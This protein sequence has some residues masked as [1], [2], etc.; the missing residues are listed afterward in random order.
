MKKLLPLFLTLFS[1]AAFSWTDPTM[2]KPL[3]P[4]VW[5]DQLKPTL[6]EG[7]D[8]TG[9]TMLATGLAGTFAV[10][11]YDQKIYEFNKDGGSFLIGKRDSHTIS[12]LG[13]G[14]LYLGLGTSQL[15]LDQPNGV[16]YLRALFL[17]TVSQ[18]SISAF[19]RRNRPENSTDYLPWPSSF[20]SGHTAAAFVTAGSLA[21]S[22]GWAAGIPAYV[23]ASAVGISRVKEDRHWASDVVAGAFIGTYWAR[24]SFKEHQHKQEVTIMPVPTTGGVALF[25]MKDW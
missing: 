12:K 25:A 24:A 22:Y 10:R 2:G 14:L 15:F 20:P 6:K 17:T 21:Y 13:N 9:V 5:E 23:F 8:G 16:K 19:T 1:F 11:T 7:I 3:I 18:V 4:W